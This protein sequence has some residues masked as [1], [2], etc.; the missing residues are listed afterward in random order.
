MEAFYSQ[1]S[2]EC[3]WEFNQC[4]TR[5]QIHDNSFFPSVQYI[6]RP[7]EWIGIL[8]MGCILTDI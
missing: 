5:N 6:Y 1:T 4:S 2:K 3:Q 7:I 8:A